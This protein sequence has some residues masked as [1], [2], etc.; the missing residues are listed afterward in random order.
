MSSIRRAKNTLVADDQTLICNVVQAALTED[1][2]KVEVVRDGA[3]VLKTYAPERFTL[4]VLDIMMPQKTGI[5]IVRELRNRNDTV[6]IILMSGHMTEEVAKATEGIA[7]LVLLAKPFGLEELRAAVE[8]V[9]G[10]IIC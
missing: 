8:R 5:E 4:L 7:N 3:E 10:K 1:G 2:H 6:P 9:A